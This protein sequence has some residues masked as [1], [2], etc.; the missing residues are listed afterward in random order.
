MYRGSRWQLLADYNAWM[1]ERLYAVCGAMSDDERKLNRGAFFKSIHSTL[2]HLVWAD[3]NWMTRL[4]GKSY[5]PVVSLGTDIF[6]AFDD[7]RAARAALDAEITAWATSLT[8]EQL[9]APYTFVSRAGNMTR[10]QPTWSFV[11][12]MFNH[13]THHRGQLTTLLS[14]AGLSYGDTDVL[15]MPHLE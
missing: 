1:N 15:L 7:L 4:A 11:S 6:A 14:Q 2:N 12:H 3:R 8:D 9:N 13:Q 10:V 5:S